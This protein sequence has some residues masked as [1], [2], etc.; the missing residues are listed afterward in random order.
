MR[1]GQKEAATMHFPD[2][3]LEYLRQEGLSLL[4]P[5]NKTQQGSHSHTG[6]VCPLCGS[7]TG[8]NGTGMTAARKDDPLHLTCWS[9]KEIEHADIFEIIGKRDGIASFPEQVMRVAELIGYRPAGS[10]LKVSGS[11]AR[12]AGTAN[13]NPIPPASD[14]TDYRNYYKQV[15]ARLSET[16]YHRGI[17]METLTR[18]QVGFDSAWRHPKAPDSVPTSPRLII[19]TSNSSYLARDTRPDA[20]VPP[21]SRP[22]TKSKVGNAHNFNQAALSVPYRQPIFIVE[23]EIDALSII[24]AGGMAVGLGGVGNVDRM[25][26]AVK[27]HQNLGNRFII[28]MDADKAGQNAAERLQKKLDDL[29]I[30]CVSKTP[31]SGF[32]DANEAL[33]ADRETFEKVLRHVEAGMDAYLQEKKEQ[34]QAEYRKQAVSFSVDEFE[35]QVRKGTPALSTGLPSL[36]RLLDGGLHPGLT[37]I[38]SISSGGKTT[39]SLQVADYIA[40]SGTDVLFFSLE[41]GRNELIAK[42]LSRLTF[43]QEQN[44]TSQTHDAFT[45]RE[46][47]AGWKY[48]CYSEEKQQLLE[49]AVRQY[50]GLSEHLFIFE[51]TGDIDVNVVR[52]EAERYIHLMDCKPL[53][54][55]DYL[56]I[57][58]PAVDPRASDK[59]NLDKSVLELKRMSRDLQIPILAV[60]SYNRANYDN[61]VNMASAKES[62]GV[63]YV[64]DTILGMQQDGMDY[65]DGESERERAGRIRRLKQK[66]NTL[67]AQGRP[68]DMQIKVLKQRNGIRGDCLLQMY[69][70]YNCFLD[71]LPE[72]WQHKEEGTVIEFD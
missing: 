71:I 68:V 33:M 38:G 50:R 3:D 34:H 53:V 43:L 47:L 14:T 7:G 49:E 55:I 66:N 12:K 31:L 67:F 51:G 5:D 27:S 46:V 29:S 70:K 19:P 62:G 48:P 61:P 28:W 18:Y 16:D 40:A 2:Q 9:C 24:D 54:V 32:K 59:Q 72:P 63:E 4:E 6:Y 17:R 45:T 11:Q 13:E 30:P 37:C 1:S 39:L 15:S 41:M 22:Y 58:S 23:S 56:Q 44:P 25:V 10:H 52:G 21:E 36:D 26:K 57:L 69:S 8:K 60:T 42:S 35:D 20:E 65:L 64:F